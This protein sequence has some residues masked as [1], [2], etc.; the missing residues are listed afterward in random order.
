MSVTVEIRDGSESYMPGSGRIHYRYDP[1]APTFFETELVSVGGDLYEGTLPAPLCPAMPQ[2]YFS[3]LGDDG[4]TVYNPEDAPGSLYVAQV[5]VK[6]VMLADD[7]ET[8]QGWTVEDIELDTGSWERG[9]P[10]G[11]GSRGDPTSDFDNSGQ[12]F[13]T[14]NGVGNYDVDGGPTRLTSPTIDLGD[15]SFPVLRYA[16]WFTNDDADEDRLD[17]EVSDDNGASWTVLESVAHT[18]GWVE[19]STQLSYYVTPTSQFKVRFSATDNPNNSVTEAAIDD[20]EVFELTCDLYATGDHDG[21]QDLD[22][23]DFSWFQTCLSGDGQ[24]FPGDTGC[25]EFDFNGD[26][27]VDLSDFEDFH[28]ALTGP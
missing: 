6:T 24:L 3:A 17:V 20:V 1:A 10:A 4:T 28:T 13:V 14:D 12:C 15:V 23:R 18:E 26:L 16:R 2:F 21:D 11:D 7:F 19:Q 9:I 8:D 27:D 25:E 22:L 5:A